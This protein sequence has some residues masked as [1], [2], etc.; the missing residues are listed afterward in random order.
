MSGNIIFLIY[1]H[2]L[3]SAYTY[4]MLVNDETEDFGSFYFSLNMMPTS[5]HGVFSEEY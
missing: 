3:N 2:C 4:G 1:D 5:M